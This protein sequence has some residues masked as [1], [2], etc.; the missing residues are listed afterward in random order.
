MAYLTTAAYAERYGLN[1]QSVRRMCERGDVRAVKVGSVWRI[2]DGREG[3]TEEDEMD[4]LRRDVAELKEWRDR[5]CSV[6]ATAR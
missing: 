4:S 5:L 2:A 3:P 6:L 1:V